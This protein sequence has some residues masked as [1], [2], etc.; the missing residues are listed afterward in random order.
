MGTIPICSSAH[1]KTSK[2]QKPIETDVKP[3]NFLRS[4]IRNIYSFD[5]NPIGM[6]LNNNLKKQK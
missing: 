4:D 3:T 6:F 1:K 5:Q 2:K